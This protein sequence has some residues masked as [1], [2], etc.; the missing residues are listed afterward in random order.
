MKRMEAKLKNEANQLK[1]IVENA[2][3]RLKN[4]PNGHLRISKSRGRIEYYFKDEE[5]SAAR[6][7]GRYMKAN[8]RKLVK[9]IAQR[10]YDMQVLKRATERVKAI[11][12]FLDKYARTSL[13][14]IYSKTN[15]IRLEL[16]DVVEVSDEEFVKQWQSVEY[17]GKLITND[18]QVIVTCWMNC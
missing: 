4:A 3:R 11:E 8:E 14:D 16:I 17:E 9:S 18:A 1:K 10:D 13:K 2:K 5:C 6:K 12:L 15:P 7:N